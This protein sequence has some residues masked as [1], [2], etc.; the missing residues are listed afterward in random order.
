MYPV[1]VLINIS[2]MPEM[3]MSGTTWIMSPLQKLQLPNHICE[4]WNLYF[5]V[6]FLNLGQ[7]IY[8][9]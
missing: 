8:K 7:N 3:K 9:N 2:S 6:H 1:C 5:G 4:W